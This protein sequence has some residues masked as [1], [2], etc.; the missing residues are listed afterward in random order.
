MFRIPP[1]GIIFYLS[2]VLSQQ[3]KKLINIPME[4][5]IVSF[6]TSFC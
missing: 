4:W 1:N 2:I 5:G 6:S 3:P